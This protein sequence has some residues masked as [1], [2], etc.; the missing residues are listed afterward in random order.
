MQ[1]WALLLAVLC[2]L[3]GTALGWLLA[4]RGV[5]R[6]R[7]RASVSSRALHSGAARAELL[8]LN[9]AITA[10][11]SGPAAKSFEAIALGMKELAAELRAAST[12]STE[13]ANG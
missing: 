2:S 7:R 5:R 9:A 12:L 13:S 8:A 4:S 10:S 6:A 1:P 11:Q 3:Q